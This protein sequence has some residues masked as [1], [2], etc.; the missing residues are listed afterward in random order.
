MFLCLCTQEK[1]HDF[2]EP[3]KPQSDHVSAKVIS[4]VKN[5]IET[6]LNLLFFISFNSEM[7]LFI[8]NLKHKKTQTRCFNLN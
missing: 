6:C 1:K 4:L 5:V 8:F 2:G 7:S 3:K